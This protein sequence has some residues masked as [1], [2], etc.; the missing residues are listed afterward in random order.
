ML[1]G[2][3]GPKGDVHVAET[4]LAIDLDDDTKV[5]RRTNSN[6][7]RCINRARFGQG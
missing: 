3:R 6:A 7:V 5:V 1:V 4:A 2:V